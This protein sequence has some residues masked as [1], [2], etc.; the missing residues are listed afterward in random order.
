MEMMLLGEPMNAGCA[1]RVGLV[2][3]IVSNRSEIEEAIGIA[4]KMIELAPLALA[5]MKRFVNDRVLPQGPAEL[6]AVRNSA[7]AAEGIRA[8]RERRKPPCQGR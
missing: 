2:N 8:F 3:R 6:A 5:T 7:E 1:Y 4:E